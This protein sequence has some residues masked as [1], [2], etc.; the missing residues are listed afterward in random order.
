MRWF[1]NDSTQPIYSQEDSQWDS[2][3]EAS[4]ISYV[5]GFELS[6]KYILVT[7]TLRNDNIF[8]LSFLGEI[9]AILVLDFDPESDVS[10]L[11][12][13]VQERLKRSLH[14]VVK[15]ERPTIASNY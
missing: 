9:P 10:G 1:R 14:I 12:Y 8:N 7:S 15:K 6:R 5:S 4:F 2:F 11:L 13:E 3:L